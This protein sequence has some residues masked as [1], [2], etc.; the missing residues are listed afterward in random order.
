MHIKLKRT[1]GMGDVLNAVALSVGIVIHRIDAPFVSGAVMRGM[2]NPVHQRVTEKHV[3]M[4]HVDLG[5]EH[6]LPVRIF[7]VTHFS[8]Q[9]QVLFH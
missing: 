7:S 9:L 6:L 3:R 2:D 4:C 8:E 1:D 5:T